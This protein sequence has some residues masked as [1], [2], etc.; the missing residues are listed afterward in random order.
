MKINKTEKRLGTKFLRGSQCVYV[1]GV[2]WVRRGVIV[3]ARDV[4]YFVHSGR[5]TLFIHQ[6]TQFIGTSS[7]ENV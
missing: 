2:T 6:S 4:I 3:G 5:H 7:R 1:M